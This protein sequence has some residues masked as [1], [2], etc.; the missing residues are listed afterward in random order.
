MLYEQHRIQPRFV[1]L[2]RHEGVENVFAIAQVGDRVVFYDD[3][4]DGFEVARLD[5]ES[6][7]DLNGCGQFRLNEALAHIR[8]G[9]R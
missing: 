9:W 6:V 4:E 3:V 5:R 2:R 8:L 7:L 1:G